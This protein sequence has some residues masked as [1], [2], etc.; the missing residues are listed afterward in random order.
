MLDYK[1]LC[2]FKWPYVNLLNT[3]FGYFLYTSSRQESQ[4]DGSKTG[5][6]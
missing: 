1:Y 2:S 4:T 6:T 5:Y 3:S